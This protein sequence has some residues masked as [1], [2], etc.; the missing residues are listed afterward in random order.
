MKLNIFQ[1]I[2]I[3]SIVLAVNIYAGPTR[4]ETNETVDANTT[5]E[6]Y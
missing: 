4:E 6:N 3:L 2:V 5:M 1:K